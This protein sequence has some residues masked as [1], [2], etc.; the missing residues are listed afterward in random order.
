MAEMTTYEP[1]TPSWVDL[2]SADT[3][4]SAQF[5]GALFG[6]DW[7]EVPDGGGYGMFTQAGKM[8]AGLGPI[9]QPGQPEA[10]TTY[11]SV[12]DADATAAK[13]TS[14]G[15]TVLAPPMDVMEA[16]RMAI[17]MDDGGAVFA[18]WQ[19]GQHPG[20]QLV[21]EPVSLC[22][23]ELASADID[24]SKAFYGAVFGWEGETGEMG[25]MTYTEWKLDGRTVG[26]M[27]A[28]GPQLPEG[29]PPHWLVYFAVAD[30]DATAAKAT[31]LGGTL[32]APPMDIPVG[33]FA[34]IADPH[35]AASGII[36][37]NPV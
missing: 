27:M 12:A 30:T 2:S 17:F 23:N 7:A 34:V 24:K 29:T 31:E 15:G 22:W 6:W 25:P 8:V 16:G 28:L 11:V 18:V 13:V 1:G 21:G 9:M 19:P 33:R 32:M 4:E 36:R 5:Y 3:K 26:G 10:W 14:A 37:M 35:G 20:A